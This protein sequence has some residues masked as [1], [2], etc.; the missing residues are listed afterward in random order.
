[1][2]LTTFAAKNQNAS[3]TDVRDEPVVPSAPTDPLVGRQNGEVGQSIP[4][5]SE[6]EEV[7][8]PPATSD[9]QQSLL[10]NKYSRSKD[11]MSVDS[12]DIDKNPFFEG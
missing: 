8:S 3:V 1:M 7:E 6:D 12:Y 4:M 10:T 9:P 2:E 5:S 11:N